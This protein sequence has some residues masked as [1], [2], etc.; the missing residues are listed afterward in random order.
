MNILDLLGNALGG[1][2]LGVILRIGNG[3]FEEFKAGRDHARKLEEAKT[4]ATIAADAAAWAAFT[5]SQQAATVPSNVAPWCA[6]IITLFRPF[7]TLTLVGVATVV[8]FYSVGT[9]RSSMAEQVNFAAFNSVGWWF[10][11]RMAKKSK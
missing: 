4:M 8:Y 3:F 10:G 9:E 5:A 1:G 6:N 7:I 2:A 11:D